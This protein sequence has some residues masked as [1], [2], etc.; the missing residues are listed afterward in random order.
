MLA[1]IMVG[2]NRNCTVVLLLFLLMLMIMMTTSLKILEMTMTMTTT[3]PLAPIS[4]I[5]VYS[6]IP[7]SAIQKCVYT[8]NPNHIQALKRRN[9]KYRLKL[10]NTFEISTNLFF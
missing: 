4:F 2:N 9:L 5:F 8:S 3:I 1:M 10:A 7:L 6:C